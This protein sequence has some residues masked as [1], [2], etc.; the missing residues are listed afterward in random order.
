L[1]LAIA[2][3][4]ALLWQAGSV[5][6]DRPAPDPGTNPQ[7]MR[8]ERPLTVPGSAAGEACAVLDANV[9]AHEAS[10]A[11]ADLR[12]FRQ[13]GNERKT[14]GGEQEVP[15][16]VSYSE[17]QPTDAT[18]ATV[19]NRSLHGGQIAFD[20][21]MPHRPYTTVDLHLA[22]TNFV[23]IAQVWASDGSVAAKTP[24]GSF[25]LFDLSGQ[26]LA[27][28]TAMALQES[29]FPRL[30][31]VLRMH[32]VK[33]EALPG[34]SAD[35]VRGAVVPASREAQTLYT[36]V[37]SSAKL[38]QQGTSTIA[39]I[40]AAA[41]VPVERVR[42][43]LAPG[44]QGS[45]LRSV[46]VTAERDAGGGERETVNG[47]IWQVRRPAADGLPAINAAKLS[48]DAVIASN[49]HEDTAV[50]V[51]VQNDGQP[52]LPLQ[53]VQLEM[54]QRQVCFDA[55]AGGSYMLRYGDEGTGA[56]VYNGGAAAALTSVPLVAQMGPEALNREYVKRNAAL[57]PEHGNPETRWIILLA[58]IAL[59]GALASRHT[60]RQGRH[61]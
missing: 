16:A 26:G 39:R 33:G 5:H 24:L 21:E 57:K 2:I 7:H 35:L 6:L 20:L 52:P 38:V 36:V 49:M 8:Y 3:C 48:I 25:V 28:S 17:A 11:G 53:A 30:H 47:R 61:R 56:A 32:G 51:A 34:L 59:L 10:A 13:T 50:K 22:A 40:E 58:A 23:A 18:I 4:A 43:V 46:S 55:V 37:A 14:A 42:F 27:R 45:F 12:V 9:F 54:R 29:S 31:V 44:Y 15:F 1:R 19:R 60:K 41:H